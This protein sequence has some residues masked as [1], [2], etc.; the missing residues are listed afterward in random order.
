MDRD[1]RRT[2]WQASNDFAVSITHPCA[3]V[4]Q[5]E[6]DIR[7][8]D[9]SPGTSDAEAFDLIV[10]FAKTRSIDHM[11]RNP[12]NLERTTYH[13]ARRPR[14]RRNDRQLIACQPVKQA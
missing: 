13:V 3:C 2:L 12:F 4:D 1:V 9:L 6:N 8:L 14:N 11:Q 7:S 10:G 5:Q